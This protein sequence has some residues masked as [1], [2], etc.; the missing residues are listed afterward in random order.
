MLSRDFFNRQE[1]CYAHLAKQHGWAQDQEEAYPI[2]ANATDKQSRHPRIAHNAL[3]NN[4]LNE[5][6]LL[7]HYNL[8]VHMRVHLSAMLE[9]IHGEACGY[10][11]APHAKLN[12][13]RIPIDSTFF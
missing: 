1:R 9:S 10:P 3:P 7:K 4:E 5:R 8:A 12:W 13:K 6:W 11:V 2:E